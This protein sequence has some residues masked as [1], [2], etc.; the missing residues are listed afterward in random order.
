[1]NCMWGL[2]QLNTVDTNDYLS[3]FILYL[4]KS[5][6]AT[7][8]TTTTSLWMILLRIYMYVHHILSFILQN[9]AGNFIFKGHKLCEKTKNASSQK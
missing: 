8:R 1:M 9:A 2:L 5:T 6:D 4:T 3:T 7:D